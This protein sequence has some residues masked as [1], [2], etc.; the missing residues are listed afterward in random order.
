VVAGDRV[1]VLT[2]EGEDEV[3]GAYDLKTGSRLWQQRYPAPY[4]M[5]SAA[6][7]HG[8]GPKSTPLVSGNEVCAFGISGKLSC[9]EAATGRLLWRK[10]FAGQFRATSP[11][12]GSAASPVLVDG[13]LIA[14][15]GGPDDGALCAFD[16]ATGALKW[17][18]KGDGPGYASPVVATL[19]GVRQVVTETQTRV[20][21][22]DLGKGTLLWSIP[23]TTAYDQNAVTPLVSGP[24]VIYS[25]MGTSLRAVRPA[26]QGGVWK[27]ETVWDAPDL[28]LYMSSPVLTD[29]R[30]VGFTHKKKGQLFALDPATGR[31]AWTSEGRLGEN[32][33]LVATGGAMLALLDDAHLIVFDASAAAYAPRA[34]YTVADS[35]TWAHP[36]PTVAGLLVKDANTLALWKFDQGDAR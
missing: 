27:V 26:R 35:P 34:T 23:F 3:L 15:V 20:V 6:T 25:G 16:A 1:F 33:A 7:S 22:V 12:Y 10:D 28:P 18:M 8:P 31:V 24:L 9:H 17:T 30:L 32:A 19:D 14:A 21:G 4:Q 29:N 36:V 5:N 11:L 13:M 2:R